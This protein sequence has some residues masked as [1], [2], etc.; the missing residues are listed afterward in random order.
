MALVG[1]RVIPPHGGLRRRRRGTTGG[2]P[3]VTRPTEA[4]AAGLWVLYQVA[5]QSEL[6]TA[7]TA[8]PLQIHLEN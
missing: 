8:V 5:V 1:P 4:L 7:S 2:M 3:P 6:T